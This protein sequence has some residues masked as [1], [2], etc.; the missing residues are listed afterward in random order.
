LCPKRTY[1][2]TADQ[3][4]TVQAQYRRNQ[5]NKFLNQ[6]KKELRNSIVLELGVDL[7]DLGLDAK[8]FLTVDGI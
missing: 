4:R 2:A 8:A 7:A 6:F 3:V 5:L 1:Y